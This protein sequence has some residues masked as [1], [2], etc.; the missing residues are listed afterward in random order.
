LW[1][2]CTIWCKYY[3]VNVMFMR[4]AAPNANAEAVLSVALKLSNVEVQF[5]AGLGTEAGVSGIELRLGSEGCR[6]VQIGLW[7]TSEADKA[8]AGS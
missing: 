7:I 1:I 5:A 2:W 4:G 3:V 8:V 6:A